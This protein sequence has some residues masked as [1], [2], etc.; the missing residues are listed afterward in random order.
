MKESFLLEEY[1]SPKVQVVEMDFETALLNVSA[2]TEESSA[3]IQQLTEWN[4]WTK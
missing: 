3:T 4:L 2:E 1:V